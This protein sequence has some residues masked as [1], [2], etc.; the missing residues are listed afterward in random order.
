[1]LSAAMSDTTL[2][3][4]G[5]FGVSGIRLHCISLWRFARI[6]S[7]LNAVSGASSLSW[8]RDKASATILSFPGMY[9]MVKEYMARFSKHL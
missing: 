5:A 4:F 3:E 2:P 8:R 1:V 7:L 6:M 9:L